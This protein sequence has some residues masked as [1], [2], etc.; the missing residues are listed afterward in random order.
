VD[1]LE[2]GN[3]D[4]LDDLDDLAELDAEKDVEDAILPTV[5]IDQREAPKEASSKVG[6]GIKKRRK[7]ARAQQDE[8]NEDVELIERRLWSETRTPKA[9][10]DNYLIY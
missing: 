9:V 3:L 1:E 6:K 5:E 2:L 4:D 8:D 7:T 10:L